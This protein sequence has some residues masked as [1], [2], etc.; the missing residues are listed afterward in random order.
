QQCTVLLATHY[1]DEA[2]ELCDRVA[3]LD[4]GRLLA[5]GPVEQ[6]AGEVRDDRYRVTVSAQHQGTAE[7]VLAGIAA[8][9]AQ[10]DERSTDDWYVLELTIAGGA[11][12]AADVI[13]RL[14][15]AGVNVAGMERRPLALADLLERIVRLKADRK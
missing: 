1:A 10:V 8:D 13:A 3:V 11:D 5:V 7:R 6:L 12:G 4:R 2:F 14:V 9:V 15:H